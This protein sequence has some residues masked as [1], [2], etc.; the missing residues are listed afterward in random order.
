[1]RIAL[2]EAPI[3]LNPNG[4]V[5]ITSY[6]KEG[7]MKKKKQTDVLVKVTPVDGGVD[8]EIDEK[9]FRKICEDQNEFGREMVLVL[10]RMFSAIRNEKEEGK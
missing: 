7:R 4:K 1:M 3:G 2:L 8:L 6:L 9:E 5:S 10:E